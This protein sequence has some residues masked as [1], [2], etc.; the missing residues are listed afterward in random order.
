[1]ADRTTALSNSR[2]LLVD[3]SDVGHQHAETPNGPART[4]LAAR[5]REKATEATGLK[6]RRS[7]SAVVRA[8]IH[9]AGASGGST[10]TTLVRPRDQRGALGS[11]HLGDV[12]SKR[13]R[14]TLEYAP[15]QA[16]QVR[17]LADGTGFL[18]SAPQPG[19]SGADSWGLSATVL[20]LDKVSRSAGVRLTTPAKAPTRRSAV[21]SQRGQAHLVTSGADSA[22]H[23]VG[24]RG[25][26]TH[27]AVAETSPGLCP[28]FPR[29][30]VEGEGD[31]VAPVRTRTGA[32]TLNEA[33]VRVPGAGGA[34]R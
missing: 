18:A 6:G 30:T 24:E 33:A 21:R 15:D 5:K 2:Y 25:H 27:C 22:S 11:A 4:A 20:T 10:R 29:H 14:T 9:D 8:D 31:M 3:V 16:D 28:G 32:G 34:G 17:E 13:R 26:T 19:G 12:A 23:W 7:A 1:M